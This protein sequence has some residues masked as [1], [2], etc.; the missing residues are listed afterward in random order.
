VTARAAIDYALWPALVAAPVAAALGLLR[1][2]AHPLLVTPL[3]VGPLTALLFVLERVRPE[4]EPEPDR[5]FGLAREAMHFLFDFELGYGVALGV[6]EIVARLVRAHAAVPPWPSHW[7]LPLQ[8]LVATLVYEGTSYWQHRALHRYS[9]LFRFH[10][11]H[12]AGARLDFAR[13]VRFH[14]VDI[15]TASLVAYLP[16]VVLGAPDSLFAILGVMLS[17]LGLLQHANVRMRT[18][19]WLDRI[20]C[21]PA[22]HRHHHSARRVDSDTNFANTLMLFDLVFGTYGKPLR[23]EGPPRIGLDDDPIPADFWGQLVGPFR[24]RR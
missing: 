6:C 11:L 9:S 14:A 24:S 18:P 3:V 10:A 23:P 15:G 1:A 22:V 2:G 12:H 8:V 13:A 16:L 4:R 21:T 17:A 5:R 7:P 19:E 20:V